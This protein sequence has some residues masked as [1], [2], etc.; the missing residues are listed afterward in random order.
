MANH[1]KHTTANRARNSANRKVQNEPGRHT[2]QAGVCVPHGQAR[3]RVSLAATVPADAAWHHVQ[4]IRFGALQSPVD[5]SGIGQV[6]SRGESRLSVM[7]RVRMSIENAERPARRDIQGSGQRRY[8]ERL[9]TRGYLRSG[10]L[11]T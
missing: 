3:A 11:K 8:D 9:G 4:P 2:R 10:E 7:R 6:E 1:T 5:P